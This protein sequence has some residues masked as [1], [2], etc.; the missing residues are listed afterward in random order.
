[1]WLGVLRAARNRVAPKRT[2][3]GVD[4]WWRVFGVAVRLVHATQVVVA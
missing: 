1:V 2:R 3:V 4:L